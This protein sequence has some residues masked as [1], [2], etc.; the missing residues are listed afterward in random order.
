M[1]LRE[2]EFGDVPRV[3]GVGKGALDDIR[4]HEMNVRVVEAGQDEFG[5][6]VD[7]RGRCRERRQEFLCAADLGYITVL[8]DE[9]LA[10]A[11][12]LC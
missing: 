6:A 12:T 4:L 8:D 7:Q 2:E 1:Q 9:S 11:R 3:R 10:A 5:R